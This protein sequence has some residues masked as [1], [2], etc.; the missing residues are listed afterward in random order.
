MEITVEDIPQ[1]TSGKTEQPPQNEEANNEVNDQETTEEKTEEKENENDDEN[2]EEE[3]VYEVE[4]ILNHRILKGVTQYY[5]KWKGYDDEEDNTWVDEADMEGSQELI[6]EYLNGIKA[7]KQDEHDSSNSEKAKT[8]KSKKKIS[9]ELKDSPIKER[10]VFDEEEDEKKVAGILDDE[11]MDVVSDNPD[12]DTRNSDNEEF[13]KIDALIEEG[14]DDPKDEDFQLSESEEERIKST[15]QRKQTNTDKN[16]YKKY[17]EST[18]I[19][20][21]LAYQKLF[22]IGTSSSSEDEKESKTAKKNKTKKEI[23]K[24]D[25]DENNS[26]DDDV[27]SDYADSNVR[28]VKPKKHS[29]SKPK[30]ATHSIVGVTMKKNAIYYQVR[31]SNGHVSSYSKKDVEEKFPRMLLQ[32]LHQL[33]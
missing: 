17:Q 33:I 32:F 18:G 15:V 2:E 30:K 22:D 21:R 27:S 20:S 12:P 19:I 3:E 26:D 24:E 8:K 1:P 9:K 14:N 28:E 29:K 16:P 10:T 13:T 25:T 6:R 31:N 5:I 4:R 7:Q 23:K 11:I